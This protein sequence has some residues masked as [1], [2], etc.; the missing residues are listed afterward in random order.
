MQKGRLYRTL[1]VLGISCLVGL[2]AIQVY[3]FNAAYNIEEKRLNERVTLALREVANEVGDAH[4]DHKPATLKRIAS[5]SYQLNHPGGMTYSALDSSVRSTFS[6]HNLT[7]P[8]QVI[9]Y[10][11][12]H[13]ILFGNFYKQGARSEAEAMCL[14]RGLANAGTE[15]ITVS[16]PNQTTD[17]VGGMP[18][19]IFSASMFIVVLS[20]M[21]VM[22]LRLSRD[23]RRAELRADFIS[24]MTHELQTPIANIA[25][26]SEVLKKGTE[27]TSRSLHYASIISSENLRLKSHLDQVL[28]TAIL[29]KGELALSKQEVNINDV[30]SEIASVFRERI[31][32][33]RGRLSVNIGALKPIVY[34]DVLHLKNILYNLLD[35]AEKYSPDAPEITVSTLDG[36]G[37]VTVSVSD[38]GMGIMKENQSRI[39]EKFFRASKGN[40][41]DIKGF[42][43]GLT[44]VKGIVEA[45]NGTVTVSS[46]PG[47]GSR[48][49]VQLQ[50]CV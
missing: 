29:E 49:D 30:V 24:N 39:F 45:H 35:N 18:L 31:Q 32:V 20:L 16:F 36:P 28:Q 42:G 6:S 13:D 17:I 21:L 4:G 37:G 22:M 23:K 33:R 9:A 27:S 8:F 14:E 7:L 5:N 38:K 40:V 15:T 41:H 48:F 1:V 26:A 34:A 10:G 50:N 2:L 46:V 11:N 19:W 44:Y 3:W 43:L 12:Q 25:L 47:Q